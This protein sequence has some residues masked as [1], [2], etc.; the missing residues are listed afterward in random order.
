MWKSYLVFDNS[1]K[2]VAKFSMLEQAISACLPGCY[3][4]EAWYSGYDD[5]DCT[6]ESEKIIYECEVIA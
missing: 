1:N 6:L 2:F 5:F 4:L 3:V